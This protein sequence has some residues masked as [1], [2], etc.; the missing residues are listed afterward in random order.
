MNTIEK[1]MNVEVS[2]ITELSTDELESV[3]G[4]QINSLVDAF[5]HGFLKTCPEAGVRSFA[6][7]FAG[8]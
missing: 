8:C 4:G 6:K 2:T 3:A 5:V 1:A 7:V